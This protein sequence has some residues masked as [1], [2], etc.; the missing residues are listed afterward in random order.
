MSE[1]TPVKGAEE[2]VDADTD[3]DADVDIATDA[4][5]DVGAEESEE[6]DDDAAGARDAERALERLVGPERL[7]AKDIKRK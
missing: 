5:A 4:G 3:A 6:D 2:R 7:G 1:S